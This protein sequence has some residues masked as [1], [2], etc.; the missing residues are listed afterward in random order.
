M[1]DTAFI[2][3]SA[4]Y[5]LMDRSDL[6]HNQASAIWRYLLERKIPLQTSNYIVIETMA[7]LQNRLGFDAANL[8]YQD[9]LGVVEVVWIENAVHN[10]ALELWLSLGRRKLSLVDCVSFMVMRQ[11]RVEK[12]FCFDRHFRD[13]GFEMISQG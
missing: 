11:Q 13:Q 12:V 10:M 6:H 4:F 5:A 2:D 8:W 7:L 1:P 9:V 3:S